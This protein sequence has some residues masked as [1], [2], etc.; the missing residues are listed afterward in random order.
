MYSFIKSKRIVCFI[1][2]KTAKNFK[3]KQKK[4]PCS[5]ATNDCTLRYE[6]LWGKTR[7]PFDERANHLDL[8][9]QK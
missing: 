5:S 4:N 3:N 6:H 1:F 2:I 8:W 9:S 7:G